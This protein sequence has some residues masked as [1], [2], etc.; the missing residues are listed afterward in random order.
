ML[1][2]PATPED[3]KAIKEIHVKTYQSCYR[4]YLP[5][6]EL[7]SMVADNDHIQRTAA[8]IQKTESWV[9]EEDNWVV[10]FAYIT[11]PEPNTFEINALYIH[12]NFQR[13]GIGSALVSKL[14][15]EKKKFGFNR[16][17][18]WTLKGGPSIGFYKKIGFTQNKGEE[19]IWKY[20]LPI[21][22]FEKAL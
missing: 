1:I 19:K 18:V 13:K 6:N 5:D 14:C 3:A 2:R 11:Y 17:V 16:L 22:Q 10:G 9:V 4:G 7:D 12:P 20:D 15:L 21:I 8:Y